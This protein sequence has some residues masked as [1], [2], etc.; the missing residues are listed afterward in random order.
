MNLHPFFSKHRQVVGTLSDYLDSNPVIIQDVKDWNM[1]ALPHVL[2]PP[3][4]AR[5]TFSVAEREELRKLYSK[6]YKTPFESMVVNCSFVKYRN[7]FM[8]GKQVGSHNS[9]SRNSSV[10]M[11]HYDSLL[12]KS[13]KS[14]RPARINYF[15]KHTVL[16]GDKSITHLLFSASFF[17]IHPQQT[18]LGQPLSIWECDIFESPEISILPV[19]FIKCRTVSLV[20]VFGDSYGN[21]LLVIPCVNF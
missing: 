13:S 4:S 11:C 2:L 7:I 10:V 1:D 14:D 18:E 6:L 21:V 8:Y 9:R 3:H 17:K 20:D 5:G 12:P 16:I 15:A 19:H